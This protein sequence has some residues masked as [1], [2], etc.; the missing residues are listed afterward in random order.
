MINISGSHGFIASNLAKLLEVK[1]IPRRLLSSKSAL[2]DYLSLTDTIIHT[3]AYGNYFFQKGDRKIFNI[4]VVYTFNLLEAAKEAGVKKFIS[5]SSSYELGTKNKPMSEDMVAR[6]ETLY[7]ITK[8]CTTQ[9]TRHF[10]KYFNTAI[11]RPFSVIG[12]GEQDCHLIPNLIKSCLYGK[13]I[14][15]VPTPVHDYINVVDL[16]SGV[17]LVLKNIKKFNGQIFHLG[18]GKQYTNQ[19]VLE[20]VEKLTGKK[21]NIKIVKRIRDY[22]S[23]FWMADNS[24]LKSLGWKQTKTLKQTIKEMI[25]YELKK[26][27][28]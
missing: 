4:N 21:A 12:V 16:C 9:L 27:N 15:F 7:G 3:A 26:K 1:P 6:P 24:K 8:T 23:K 17:I 28:N 19:E 2:V 25:N 5:F 22:D 11:V 10:S 14:P 18:C 20:I 13:K